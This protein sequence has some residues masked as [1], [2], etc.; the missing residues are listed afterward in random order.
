MDHRW[1]VFGFGKGRSIGRGSVSGRDQHL[2]WKEKVSAA[3]II[4]DDTDLGHHQRAYNPDHARDT[5]SALVIGEG[6]ADALHGDTIFQFA[7]HYD[8]DN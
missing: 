3:G 8:P 6:N 5:V 4:I 2:P 7:L 1:H